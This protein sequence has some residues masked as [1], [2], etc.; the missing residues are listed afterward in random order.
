MPQHSD[1]RPFLGSNELPSFS[2]IVVWQISQHHL[3]ELHIHIQNTKPV[4]Q[5]NDR[6]IL[7]SV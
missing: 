1:F 3:S 2:S 7:D 5:G 6:P 4:V